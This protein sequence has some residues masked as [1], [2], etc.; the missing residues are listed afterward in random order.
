M[1][2]KIH[3]MEIREEG[4]AEGNEAGREEGILGIVEILHDLGFDDET[5]KQKIIEKYGLDP[6][7]AENY[8]N[9]ALVKESA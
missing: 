9:M 7:E 2:K 8:L 1:V 3:E 4:W 5:I 6:G